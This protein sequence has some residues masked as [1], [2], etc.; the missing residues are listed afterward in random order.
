MVSKARDDFPEPERP[1]ITVMLSFGIFTSI[2]F[3]L[4]SLAPTILINFLFAIL[5]FLDDIINPRFLSIK[6]NYK[7]LYHS[8]FT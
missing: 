1:V 2:F 6:Y 7:R 8:A 3:R 5:S 4:C